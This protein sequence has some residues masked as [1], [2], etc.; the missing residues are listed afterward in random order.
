MM[1]GIIIYRTMTPT[2]QS[3][4]NA[5]LGI[6]FEEKYRNKNYSDVICDDDFLSSAIFRRTIHFIYM[7]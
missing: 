7:Y 1:T 5:D 4:G 3:L 2:E 6:Y